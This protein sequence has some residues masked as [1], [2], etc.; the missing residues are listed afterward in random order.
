MAKPSNQIAKML[1]RRT[2]LGKA[3]AIMGLAGVCG[4]AFQLN[5]F[6]SD[7]ALVYGPVGMTRNDEAQAR[8]LVRTLVASFGA[9]DADCLDSAVNMASNA[10]NNR[11]APIA[12]RDAKF[13]RAEFLRIAHVAE[14]LAKGLSGEKMPLG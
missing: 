4:T 11:D 6:L 5:E 14:G 1:N 10:M 13:L 7:P 2:D 8:E 9:V 12:P 3:R